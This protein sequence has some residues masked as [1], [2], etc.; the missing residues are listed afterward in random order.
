MFASGGN[1]SSLARHAN[2]RSAHDTSIR[3]SSRGLGN[4][5]RPMQSA[6]YQLPIRAGQES[7]ITCSYGH[8]RRRT[9]FIRD[10]YRP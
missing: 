1:A 8:G 7:E 6:K 5:L 9:R 4:P 10:R 2:T 3:H